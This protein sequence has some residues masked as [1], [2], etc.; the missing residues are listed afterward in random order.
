VTTDFSHPDAFVPAS[1]KLEAVNRISSI[2]G[3]PPE[4]LGPGS[5]ERKSVLESLLRALL[6]DIDPRGKTK[7][8]LGAV[9]ASELGV[10]WDQSCWST[11]S[12]ITLNGLNQLLHGAEGRL[13][14]RVSEAK[15]PIEEALRIVTQTLATVP[16]HLDGWGAV[17]TMREAGSAHWAQSEWQGFYFEFLTIPRCTALFG[18]GP[19]RSPGQTTFDYMGRYIWD[20]KTHSESERELILNDQAAIRWALE[21]DGIGF[22]VLSGQPEYD[23]MFQAWFSEYKVEHGVTPRPRVGQP[24][25]HRRFK[26]GFVPK[27]VQAYYFHDLDEWD[28]ARADGAIKS[29]PQPPQPDRRPRNPKD[30]MIMSLASPWLAAEADF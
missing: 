25:Y 30:K 12:T 13:G 5:K 8:Q 26:S 24:A 7:P 28:R 22:I 19:V 18:G 14:R 6:L 11:G 17:P 29:W 15:S 21:T 4:S 2:A 9:L 20:F 16:R 27:R 3:G 10:T 23:D 1:D